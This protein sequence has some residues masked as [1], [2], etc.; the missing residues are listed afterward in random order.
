M[1][2]VLIPLSGLDRHR[3]DHGRLQEKKKENCELLS[4]FGYKDPSAET[5]LIF[6]VAEEGYL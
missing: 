1:N 5:K 6:E 4:F 3:Q 2:S